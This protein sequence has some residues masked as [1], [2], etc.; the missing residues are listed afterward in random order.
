MKEKFNDLSL[1]VT[2]ASLALKAKVYEELERRGVAV[3]VRDD[4]GN[5]LRWTY[6]HEGYADIITITDVCAHG[7][8]IM[9]GFETSDGT[10]TELPIWDFI[11]G[12]DII[13]YIQWD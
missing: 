13:D 2:M 11:D 3:P 4:D 8:Q 5:P 10:P 1:K 12:I 7:G 9:V 6:Y